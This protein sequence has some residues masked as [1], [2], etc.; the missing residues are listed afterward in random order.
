MI[1][2]NI[3]NIKDRLKRIKFS[4]LFYNNKFVAGF[5]VVAAFVVWVAVSSNSAGSVPVT[6]SNIPVDIHLSDSAV[7]DGLRVF[8]REDITAHVQITGNRLIVGQVTKDDIQITAPQA[9]STIMSPGKYMLEL[10][11]K[12]VGV[13]QD[14]QIVSDVVPSVITVT[15]DRYRESEFSIEPDIKFNPKPDYFVGSTVLSSPKVMLSGPESEISQIK[16]VKVEGSI[17]GEVSMPA[18]LKLPIVMY[19]AYDRPITSEMISTNISEVE[20]TVPVLMKKEIQLIPSFSNLP[21]GINFNKEYK[22]FVKI[23]PSVLEIAGPEDVIGSL[24]SLKLDAVDFNGVNI[25][26]NKFSAPINLPQGCRSLNNI[27]S[28]D[29]VFNMYPFR[30]KTFSVNNFEFK[31]VPEGKTASAY[32]GEI[33]VTVLAPASKINHVKSSDIVAEINF[34]NTS[35]F[36]S[37]MEMPIKFIVNNHDDVWIS[38]NYTVNVSLN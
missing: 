11:A 27:Y 38:G 20:V 22:D 32:S 29:I 14:Y 4:K 10:T 7:Q 5:S 8:S 28:A 13:L 30:E 35:E 21:S 26:N 31:N 37:S 25:Q 18:T 16:K 9:A 1:R 12:K 15:V 34:E 3:K 2:F 17:P 33:N 23:T 24:K 36:L 19:D 6:V